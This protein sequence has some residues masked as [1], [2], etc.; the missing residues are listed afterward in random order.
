MPRN[1]GPPGAKGPLTK[2]S[3]GTR[4]SL[5]RELVRA[6]AKVAEPLL[7][8]VQGWWISVD[9]AK[10]LPQALVEARN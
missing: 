3:F 6:H 7:A 2:P 4:M 10:R 1:Q 8:D 5:L 9:G